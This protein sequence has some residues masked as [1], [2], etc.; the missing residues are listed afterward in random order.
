MP[1]PRSRSPRILPR[2]FSRWDRV[3]ARDPWGRRYRQD[4]DDSCVEAVVEI[5]I[6][7]VASRELRAPRASDSDPVPKTWRGPRC[8]FERPGIPRRRAHRRADARVIHHGCDHAASRGDGAV[9]ASDAA[10]V[11]PAATNP[12]HSGALR[13]LPA[14]RRA[15]EVMRRAY[16]SATNRMMLHVGQPRPGQVC[17]GDGDVYQSRVMPFQNGES[18]E[19]PTRRV[20]QRK[21]SLITP[22]RSSIN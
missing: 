5:R 15:A 19:D 20:T 8:R 9:H 22:P 17:C 21:A 7:R 1:S 11:F 12:H 4:P 10:A 16:G 18:G 6:P 14:R 2:S 3:P 13:M